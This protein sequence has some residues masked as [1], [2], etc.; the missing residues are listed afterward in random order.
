MLAMQQA[1]DQVCSLVTL[2]LAMHQVLL[3]FLTAQQILHLVQGDLCI[4]WVEA[5][6]GSG[7]SLWGGLRHGSG[8]RRIDR[9]IMQEK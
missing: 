5:T 9:L 4:L 6:S 3:D 2:L 8:N 7:W 1:L